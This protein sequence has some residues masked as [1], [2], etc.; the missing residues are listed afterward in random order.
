[1]SKRLR[2]APGILPVLSVLSVLSFAVWPAAS[3]SAEALQHFTVQSDGHPLAV[4]ARVP[5]AP[6]G[7]I[8]L[9]HGRTWSSRPD[10]D[11]QVPGL[12]RSVLESLEARGFAAYALDARGYGATP[13]DA[14]GWLTPKRAAADA[15]AV[16]R[17]IAGRHPTL[18]KPALL[19]WSLGAAV[20]HLTAATS[21]S[22]MSS[23]I[24]FGYAPDP[25]GVI[26]PD[27][28]DSGPPLK[29]KTTAEGAASDFIS[30]KV[31]PA[32]VIKA[33]VETATKTDP[34][35]TD[36]RNEDQF[37]YDSGRISI[38]ALVMYGE[39]DPG[40]DPPAAN[41][42]VSRLKNA[43]KQLVMIPGADHCAHLED[44]HDTWIAAVVT[45]L[46]KKR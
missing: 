43:D 3:S 5:P 38:P 25:D 2:T 42:F 29:E 10:F 1:M 31:T 9:L 17:W 22:V 35:L 6:R 40:V 20:A 4:W 24:L 12:Q 15:A 39:R 36:W 21:P 26:P 18:P 23:V 37:V 14:S 41:R 11:L 33:F 13:R 30:P 19:G 34:I 28:P 45:F 46:S 44:T 27:G 16:L 32:A 8:L 7:A